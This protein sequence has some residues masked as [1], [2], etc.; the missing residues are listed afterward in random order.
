MCERFPTQADIAAI[1]KTMRHNVELTEE[2]FK[3]MCAMPEPIAPVVKCRRCESCDTGIRSGYQIS[4][5]KQYLYAHMELCM[6]CG[7]NDETANYSVVRNMLQNLRLSKF[8]LFNVKSISR[9]YRS[10]IGHDG[11]RIIDGMDFH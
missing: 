1:I 2:L 3:K 7:S 5:D 11:R 6:N 8:P 10:V 4:R 9:D